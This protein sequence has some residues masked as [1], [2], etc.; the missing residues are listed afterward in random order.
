MKICYSSNRKLIWYL[1]MESCC[2]AYLH[3]C[4]NGLGMGHWAEPG[5][6]LGSMT[7]SLEQITNSNVDVKG[8]GSEGSEEVG[9]MVEHKSS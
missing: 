7:D 3:I 5:R 8:F 4:R 9:S 6:I 1:K 2:N